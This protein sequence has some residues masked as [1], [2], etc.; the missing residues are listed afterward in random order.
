MEEVT[1]VWIK[2]H[3]EG[4]LSWYYSPDI[5]REIK[6]GRMWLA[7]CAIRAGE[8][9]NVHNLRCSFFREVTQRRLVV[10]YRRFGTTYRFHPQGLL[11]EDAIPKR[12]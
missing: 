7:D 4:M 3:R 10:S 8:I 5:I 11:L 1:D 6:L 2:L 9:K 12:R